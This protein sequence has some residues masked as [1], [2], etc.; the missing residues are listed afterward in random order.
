MG[1]AALL[2]GK[3]KRCPVVLGVKDLSIEGLL[4]AE[5]LKLGLFLRSLEAIE[6][7]LYKHADHIQV[8]T[9]NQ[10]RY[11]LRWGLLTNYFRLYILRLPASFTLPCTR[12]AAFRCSKRLHAV[13]R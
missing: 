6:R 5:K 1:F 3:I 10:E 7:Q 2:L 12:E 8:P 13:A 11:L 4:Q 9:S